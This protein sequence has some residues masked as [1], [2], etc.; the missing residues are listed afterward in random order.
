MSDHQPGDDEPAGAA[1]VKE[2]PHLIWTGVAVAVVVGLALAAYRI[3]SSP[4]ADELPEPSVREE[5]PDAAPPASPPRPGVPGVGEV[6]AA[7]DAG[8]LARARHLIARID[9][10][11]GWSPELESTMA[12]IRLREE[13]AMDEVHTLIVMVDPVIFPGGGKKILNEVHVGGRVVLRRPAAT[14]E[15]EA[16]TRVF[17]PDGF[18]RAFTIRA[19]RR[20]G[21][22][23]LWVQPGGT[24]SSTR[25][26]K[27]PLDL[28]PALEAALRDPEGDGRT[29]G[30][31]GV[32][33]ARLIIDRRS[34]GLQVDGRPELDVPPSTA[35]ACIARSARALES[36]DRALAASAMESLRAMA[37]E[38]PDLPLL[39]AQLARLNERL[40]QGRPRVRMDIIQL[41]L[42]PRPGRDQWSEL[43]AT[44]LADD[45]AV[46]STTGDD[47]RRTVHGMNLDPDH[48]VEGNHIAA[49]VEGDAPLS[50]S[51]VDRSPLMGS[52]DV[53][54]IDLGL[55]A[56]DL[57]TGTGT[58]IVES[59]PD[60]LFLPEGDE[61]R[62]RRL[63]LR[64][65]VDR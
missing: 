16:E 42:E 41:V 20:A 39:E 27:G 53:G 40:E 57:P 33:G 62:V 24:F 18:A 12:R 48:P 65:T 30:G 29:V 31:G 38:H 9:E 23:V 54:I 32:L 17:T 51:I 36:D 37:P 4:V 28:R 50:V 15:G 26:V 1:E 44:L 60:V 45:E 14:E 13:A 63:V 5:Q 7:I 64:W 22:E 19:T 43:K 47:L 35:G 25:T 10:D 2:R 49:K 58:L 55:T 61:G 8:D 11:R 34:A 56:A 6:N 59:K 46:G 52:K 21:A 3:W